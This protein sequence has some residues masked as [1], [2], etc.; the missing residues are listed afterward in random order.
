M[1]LLVLRMLQG[2]ALGGEYGGAAV[3]VAEHAPRG[4]RGFYTAFIQTTATLGLLL[5]LIII[6]STQGYVNGAFAPTVTT[7]APTA[8]RPPSRPSSPG[9]GAYRSSSPACYSASP[10]GS[11]CR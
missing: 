10:S 2:L 5:S 11:A 8:P 6:L 7:A 1:T 3:Y 9:A 4:R